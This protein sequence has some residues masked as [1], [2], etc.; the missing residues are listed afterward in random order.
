MATVQTQKKPGGHQATGRVL[1][2]QEYV[3]CSPLRCKG[4]VQ[5]S[6][7]FNRCYHPKN[8]R[9]GKRCDARIVIT[10]ILP[11]DFLCMLAQQGRRDGIY[12]WREAEME[13]RF[14]ICLLYTSDAAD[15]L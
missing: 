14:D 4:T 6:A 5:T 7:N 11:Q 15:D 2:P 1:Q 13:R 12:G 10:E 3:T 8:P 9:L